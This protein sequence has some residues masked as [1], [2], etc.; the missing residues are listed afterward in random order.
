MKLKQKVVSVIMPVYNAGK[1]LPQCMESLIKQSYSNIEIIVVNDKSKDNSLKILQE[2]KKDYNNIHIL[3]N[4]KHYGPAVCLNRATRVA[5][6]QFLA[7][8]NPCDYI[9]INKFKRQINHLLKNPKTVAVGSQFVT[10]SEHNKQLKKSSL[11]QDHEEIYQALLPSL[12]LKPET[13]MINRMLLPKDILHFSTNKYP[14]MFTE[15]FIKLLQYGKITNLNQPLYKHRVGIRRYTRNPS[16]L[17]HSFSLLKLLLKS[18][19]T[20]D[21]KPTFSLPAIKSLLEPQFK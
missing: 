11:P 20:Y 19:S 17:N 18:R 4:K 2:F 3:Q 15:I 8:M 7:L 21:Y 10:I 12:S 6:G 5:S 9:S 13:V 16:K 1:F 14:L